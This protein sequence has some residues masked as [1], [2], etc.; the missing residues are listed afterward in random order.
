MIA[1][2]LAAAAIA[3]WMTAQQPAMTFS[4]LAQGNQSQMEDAREAVART[5]AEWAALW[6]G[7]RTGK[8]PDVDFTRSMVVAVFL[9]TRPTAGYAV[10]ITGI[11]T[12]DAGLVVTYRERRPGPDELTA[13]VLTAPFHIV[14]TVAFAGPVRFQRTP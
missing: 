6:K 5:P 3:C 9:G 4:T 12:K 1:S 13:Q 11:E 7:H 8:P 2:S 14:Q 10:E